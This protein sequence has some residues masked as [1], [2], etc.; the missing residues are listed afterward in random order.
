MSMFSLEV[1]ERLKSTLSTIRS[2]FS[3]DPYSNGLMDSLK[4]AARAWRSAAVDISSAANAV[5]DAARAFQQR[6]ERSTETEK[7][8]QNP[9]S[10]KLL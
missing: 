8:P 7:T 6:T 1:E 4:D 9:F 5:K 2:A 10:E 3:T